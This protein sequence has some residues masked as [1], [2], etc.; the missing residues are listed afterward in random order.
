M[1]DNL[2]EEIKRGLVNIFLPGDVRELRVLTNKG[3]YSGYFDDLDALTEAAAEFDGKNNVYFTINPVNPALLSRAEN[4]IASRV[5]NT[6]SDADIKR[7]EYLPID[8]DPSRPSGISSMDK[9]HELA[10]KMALTIK[11]YLSKLGFP[12]PIYADS[13]NG[14]H[15]LYRVDLPNDE[16]SRDL[17]KKSLQLLDLKF[18]RQTI[19]VDT[20]TFNPARIWKLYGTMACKGDDTVDRPHR[21]SKIK[22]CPDSIQVVNRKLLEKLAALMPEMTVPK[23]TGKSEGTGINV[24]DKLK[25]YDIETTIVSRWQNKATKYIPKV[26]PWNP[27]HTNRSAYII[28][29]DGGQI[30]AGCHHTSCS[31][32]DW[33]SLRDKY[34]PGWQRN[35]QQDSNNG[36]EQQESACDIL[37]RIGQKTKLMHDGVEDVY[38]EISN[39]GHTE[40][41]KLNSRKYK[42]WLTKEFFD[43][44]GKAPGSDSMT[45]A[46]NTLQAKAF[47]DGEFLITN[48]RVAG[49]DGKFYYDLA[50]QNP[51]VICIASNRCSILN[52]PPRLFV[53]SKNMKGQVEPDFDG[54]FNLINKHFHFKD[55]DDRILFTV[56][57]ISCFVPDIPHPVLVL[58]GE[59]GAA[60]STSMR[61]AKAVVDPAGQD[62]LIMP[63]SIDDLVLALSNSYMPCFDNLDRITWEKSDILCMASTGGSFS[64]RKLYSD[65]DETILSFKRCVAVNGINVVATRPDLLDRSIVL[66]LERIEKS[67]RKAESQIWNEFNSDLP[68]IVGAALNT[69]SK[70]MIIH[71]T[72]NLDDL[73]RMAD[74]ARW[75]YAIAEVLGIGGSKFI[76]AYKKN[77]SKANEEAVA[78]HPVAEAIDAMMRKRSQWAG[79]TTELLTTLEFI[80][81][82]EKINTRHGLWPKSASI[83]SRRLNEIKSNL[84]DKG[85]YFDKRVGNSKE[86]MIRNINVQTALVKGKVVPMDGSTLSADEIKSLTMVKKKKKRK[87]SNIPQLE[88]PEENDMP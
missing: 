62:L 39:N 53:R 26:C 81:D 31:G 40:I 57:L 75:G 1:D 70:A 32:N 30:V 13:G 84:E 73:P 18:S 23:K 10:H 7:I 38:A 52:S 34:E 72:V 24:K 82:K 17:I 8:L 64:K 45:A 48:R 3:T 54:D 9:E 44:T 16:P 58:S 11:K 43:E 55:E 61:M 69:L 56:Y 19:S 63:N 41:L 77:Q 49:E 83:L 79:T 35:S 14:A 60:K 67:Q 46:L 78:A 80:A 68:Q 28:Q 76:K 22:D 65:D 37:I 27:D 50:G 25:E 5:R 47:Y 71:P 4:R 36:D 6:T 29:F 59:K 85:I 88:L 12:D 87:S 86:L 66:E 20:T 15:L 42:M 74:F 2:Y 21:R 33:H 51:R